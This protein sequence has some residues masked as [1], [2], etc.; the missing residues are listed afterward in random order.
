M[1]ITK[2]KLHT[3]KRN[4]DNAVKAFKKSHTDFDKACGKVL[5]SQEKIEGARTTGRPERPLNDWNREMQGTNQTLNTAVKC[6]QTLANTTNQYHQARLQL[7]E[8]DKAAQGGWSSP[9][10]ASL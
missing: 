2:E 9:S 10:G 4:M 8:Q 7:A 3:L 6:M 1:A 5:K